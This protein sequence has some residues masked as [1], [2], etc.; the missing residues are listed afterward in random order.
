MSSFAASSR[1]PLDMINHK[2]I[3]ES[4]YN[5]THMPKTIQTDRPFIIETAGAARFVETAARSQ[6]NV[7]LAEHAGNAAL[8]LSGIEGL[9]TGQ[10]E[11]QKRILSGEDKQDTETLL[12]SIVEKGGEMAPAAEAVLVEF[13]DPKRFWDE[14][15]TAKTLAKVAGLPTIPDDLKYL[16]GGFY[17]SG[18]ISAVDLP[19][20]RHD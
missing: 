19:S 6:G 18:P 13:T 20:A 17:D 12:R 5:K 2:R 15:H 1:A 9:S 10:R 14:I 16:E 4:R 7:V 8:H 11:D 3:V